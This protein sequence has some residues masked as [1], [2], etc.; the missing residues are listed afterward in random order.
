[1]T[2]ISND[3]YLQVKFH[4]FRTSVDGGFENVWLLSRLSGREILRVGPGVNFFLTEAPVSSSTEPYL[5]TLACSIS[6]SSNTSGGRLEV[7]DIE[8]IIRSFSR[9]SSLCS[10]SRA[11]SESSSSC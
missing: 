8:P 7:I 5:P 9:I 3:S 2:T 1:M 4:G 11:N 6:N 10:L